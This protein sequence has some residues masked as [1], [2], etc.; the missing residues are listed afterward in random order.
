MAERCWKRE[1]HPLPLLETVYSTKCCR[2]SIHH[3]SEQISM[4]LFFCVNDYF[5]FWTPLV[6]FLSYRDIPSKCKWPGK[7]DKGTTSEPPL[8]VNVIGFHVQDGQVI[9]WTWKKTLSI[10]LK[11]VGSWEP[12]SAAP[13]PFT[14]LSRRN[15]KKTL[16]I[17]ALQM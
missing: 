11:L 16:K 6:F 7:N 1:P 12:G 8:K 2:G 5:T 3:Y 4:F 14:K 9:F 15:A 10:W 13:Y 17:C